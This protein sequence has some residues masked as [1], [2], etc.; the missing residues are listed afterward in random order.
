MAAYR[1]SPKGVQPIIEE[2]CSLAARWRSFKY[3]N[4][5]G[6][7]WRLQ[8]DYTRGLPFLPIEDIVSVPNLQHLELGFPLSPRTLWPSTNHNELVYRPLFRQGAP[9]LSTLVIRAW[10]FHFLGLLPTHCNLTSLTIVS[11]KEENR[12]D[13]T[14]PNPIPIFQL[15]SIPTLRQFAL[16][17]ETLDQ[18]GVLPIRFDRTLPA[19]SPTAAAQ[20]CRLHSLRIPA[21]V[22]PHLFSCPRQIFEE[23]IHLFVGMGRGEEHLFSNLDGAPDIYVDIFPKL[24]FLTFYPVFSFEE[25]NFLMHI[26]S[27]IRHLAIREYMSDLSDYYMDNASL[28]AWPNLAEF[29]LD[30]IDW[31]QADDLHH[32]CLLR[33]EIQS[34][35]TLTIQDGLIE[36]RVPMEDKQRIRD[37]FFKSG[38]MKEVDYPTI[39]EADKMWLSNFL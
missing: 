22:L 13:N 27:N 30:E 12:H 33:R 36:G 25:A 31:P 7:A 35:F 6:S 29:Y 2:I 11:P 28:S 4:G 16:V 23:M 39:P 34:G 8:P 21:Q 3:S 38:V 1:I 24:D 18:P 19:H 20:Y 17:D 10:R 32:W 14:Q 15:L 37:L 5:Q 9:K 26:T